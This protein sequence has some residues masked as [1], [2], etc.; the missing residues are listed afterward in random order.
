MYVHVLPDNTHAAVG[1]TGHV[2]CSP[3]DRALECP[4]KNRLPWTLIWPESQTQQMR[5]F[6]SPQGKILW[7]FGLLLSGSFVET[8]HSPLLPPNLNPSFSF[9][10]LKGEEVL[11]GYVRGWGLS[12]APP[13]TVSE[14]QFSLCP[15][16]G[17]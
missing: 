1:G 3:R 7:T 12:N 15:P 6:L 11:L 14:P 9:F 10:L 4:P 13:P 17:S 5:C 8:E 2:H 16:V